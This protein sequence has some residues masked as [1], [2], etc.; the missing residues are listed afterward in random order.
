MLI[1]VQMPLTISSYPLSFHPFPRLTIDDYLLPFYYSAIA[2]KES[3]SG[4]ETEM[5]KIEGLVKEIQDEMMY[6]KKREMRFQKTNRAYSPQISFQHYTNHL[7]I[8]SLMNRV[9]ERSSTKLRLVHLRL[10]TV[11]GGLANRPSPKFLQEKISYR[12]G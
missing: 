4:L 12:L 3:L 6:L 8:Q 11:F 1:L 10:I 2:A 7:L 5:R 9:N